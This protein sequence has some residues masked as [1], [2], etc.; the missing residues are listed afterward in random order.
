MA[1]PVVHLTNGIPDSGTGNITTLGQVAADGGMVT[2]GAKADAK[3]TATDTTAVTAMS[4]WKQISASV[5]ALATSIVEVG[6]KTMA[7]VP[8]VSIASDYV[9]SKALTGYYLPCGAG[10]TTELKSSTSAVGDYLAGVLIVPGTT[11]PGAVTITDGN[12]SA[13]TIFTGGASSVSNLVPFFVPFG[14]FSRNT[15]SSGSWHVTCGANVTAV[16]VG[17]FS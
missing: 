4:V 16:A 2:I 12:G 15:L 10:A 3:S 9:L 17:K 1:D 14:G 8:C 7:A 6:Q 13:I 11:S 5:Q